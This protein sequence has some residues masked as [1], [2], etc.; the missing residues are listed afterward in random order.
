VESSD[1]VE[2]GTTMCINCW[3]F[4]GD[5][6]DLAVG[7]YVGSLET[8]ASSG[9]GLV[10]AGEVV[11]KVTALGSCGVRAGLEAAAISV[12]RWWA[13]AE[14]SCWRQRSSTTRCLSAARQASAARG[15]ATSASLGISASMAGG[16][17]CGRWASVIPKSVNN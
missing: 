7:G 1:R 5:I 8:L 14:A 17:G 16:W 6:L 13:A 10:V 11:S 15:A 12:E 4:V 9:E 3:H 2:V